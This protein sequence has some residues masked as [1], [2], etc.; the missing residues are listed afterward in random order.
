MKMKNVSKFKKKMIIVVAKSDVFSLRKI[1]EN[2]DFF[3]SFKIRKF[4]VFF[5]SKLTNFCKSIENND[6]LMKKIK[7][8]KITF[9]LK[10]IDRLCFCRT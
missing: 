6:E 5:R 7:N 10:K 1:V 4:K 8:A 9:I 3:V 2:I